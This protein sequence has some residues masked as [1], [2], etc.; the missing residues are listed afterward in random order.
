[1]TN[2]L[3]QQHPQPQNTMIQ[4]P[5]VGDRATKLSDISEKL[6]PALA[7]SALQVH[8][9]DIYGS[10]RGHSTA[11]HVASTE[12]V[13]IVN[14]VVETATKVC[15]QMLQS[16]FDDKKD[17]MMRP[18]CMHRAVINAHHNLQQLQQLSFLVEN[19]SME[20]LARYASL[21]D[22]PEPTRHQPDC[23]LPSYMANPFEYVSNLLMQACDADDSVIESKFSSFSH[24]FSALVGIIDDDSEC[25][26]A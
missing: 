3:L 2:A 11:N 1:L 22:N 5:T 24:A 9:M 8:G 4:T 10:V 17:G 26:Y 23:T 12:L 25:I 13:T 18:H 14:I 7:A 20:I 6:V 15:S 19:A 21:W 16:S